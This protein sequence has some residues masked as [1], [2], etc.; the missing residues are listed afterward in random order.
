MLLC[1]KPAGAAGI[2][3]GYG[4]TLSRTSGWLKLHGELRGA[5]GKQTSLTWAVQR[6][7][8]VPV[9]KAGSS[10][11]GLAV[12][13]S[14]PWA[15]QAPTKPAATGGREQEDPCGANPSPAEGGIGLQQVC[16]AQEHRAEILPAGTVLYLKIWQVKSRVRR[17]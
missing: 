5:S 3:W 1:A 9:H 6:P 11:N 4:Q 15:R 17:A 12:W 16:R 7:C 8:A 13:D 2:H 14:V 10:C